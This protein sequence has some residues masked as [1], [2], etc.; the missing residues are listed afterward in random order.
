MSSKKKVV[1]APVNPE[2]LG[3]VY[4][5][6]VKNGMQNAASS[7]LKDAKIDKAPSSDSAVD[8]AEAITFFNSK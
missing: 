3:S 8:V 4:S 2:V 7:L 5:F 1:A 6:L